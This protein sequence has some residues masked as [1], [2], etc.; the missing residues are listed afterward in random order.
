VLFTFLVRECE[1]L[2]RRGVALAATYP[3]ICDQK[4]IREI[5]M[6]EM[7]AQLDTRG[8]NCPLPILKTRQAIKQ[9]RSGEVLEVTS[10]DPGSMKDIAAFCEQTG[11]ELVSS[12]EAADGYVFLIKK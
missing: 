8:L 10:T 5:I 2:Y 12:M 3:L 11:H 4:D 7:T 6:T 9:L 1:G